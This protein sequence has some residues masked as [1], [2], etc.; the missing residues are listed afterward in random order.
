MNDTKPDLSR[1]AIHTFTNKPWN[2]AQ[3]IEH[4]TR[5]GIP[6]MS[7]W[8]NLLDPA[9][10]GIGLTEAAKRVR[11]S[12]LAIP[13]L[14]RGGFFPGTDAAARHR[15]VDLNRQY[16]DE[17]KALGA[18]MVVLVVGAVPGMPMAEAR[19]QVREGIGQVV[20]H[21]A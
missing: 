12:G 15:A 6:G 18:E 17:A 8:R 13:A 3:C 19:R 10:G 14:V 5:K 1:L 11:D 4:Y 9:E 7:V 2:L 21:A 16:V 20:D